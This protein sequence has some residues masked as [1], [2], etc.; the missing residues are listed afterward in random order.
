[1]CKYC[2][3]VIFKAFTVYFPSSK[4]SFLVHFDLHSES[5]IRVNRYPTIFDIWTSPATAVV[6]F[7]ISLML[8]GHARLG[9]NMDCDICNPGVISIHQ[10]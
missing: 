3:D 1:M 2:K 6:H 9:R 5:R 10:T 4:F 7:S 8:S